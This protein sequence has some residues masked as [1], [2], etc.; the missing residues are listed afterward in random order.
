LKLP[1]IAFGMI[2]LNGEPFTQYNLRSLYPCAY[3]IVVAE[4]IYRMAV[5]LAGVGVATALIV[6]SFTDCLIANRWYPNVV[7]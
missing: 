1:R 4:G 3:Q 7:W 2:V 6:N 5:V